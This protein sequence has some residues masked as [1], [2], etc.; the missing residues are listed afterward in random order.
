M[1]VTSQDRAALLVDGT[2]IPPGTFLV[3]DQAFNVDIFDAT[4]APIT[5]FAGPITLMFQIDPPPANP[6]QTSVRF[7]DTVQG[8]WVAVV[9]T[10]SATGKV[11][12]VIDHLTVF[13]VFETPAVN[14]AFGP[15][16][17]PVTFAGASGTS[18]A[19]F[20]ASFRV[21][22]AEVWR[23]DAATQGYQVF[24]PT[25]PVF[26][27]TLSTLTNRDTLFVRLESGAFTNVV[28]NDVIPALSGT[29]A[30]TLRPGFTLVSF[31]VA[32]GTS[33]EALLD[34]SGLTR[35]FRW[36]P[37]SQVWDTFFGGQPAFLSSFSTINRLDAV[38]IFNGS[39]VPVTLTVPDVD[40]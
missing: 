20:V 34:G 8:E 22:V 29:R 10:V 28:L 39:G 25:G 1:V 26:A 37:V 19:D 23:F 21:A 27:N 36:D 40:G 12:I 2:P 33:I 16:L 13:A 17:S 9:A 24:R 7:F 18:V 31:G 4:G 30:V 35:A 3:G 6:S 5:Q 38:F 14:V 15:G 11:T 32:D